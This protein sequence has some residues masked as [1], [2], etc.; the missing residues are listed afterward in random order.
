MSQ[1]VYI[2]CDI[3]LKMF[4][5][6]TGDNYFETVYNDSNLKNKKDLLCAILFRDS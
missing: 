1:K 6:L 4:T 3:T 5:A 2:F